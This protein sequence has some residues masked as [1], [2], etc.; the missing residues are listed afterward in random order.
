MVVAIF[1]FFGITISQ[2]QANRQRPEKPPTFSELLK[3]MD[4]NQDNKLS[5]KEIKGPLKND[6][7]KIDSN[8]DGFI[9]KREFQKAPKPERKK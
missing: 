1:F 3:Q 8:E 4:A 5:K 7:Y 9:T 2:A 6:F